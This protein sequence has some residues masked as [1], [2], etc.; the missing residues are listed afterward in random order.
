AHSQLQTYKAEIPSLF[1]FNEILVISDGIEARV[2]SLTANREW[3]LPWRTIE[4]EKA[5][6]NLQ[7]ELETM[8]RGLFDRQRLLLYLR[9]FITFEDDRGKLRKILAGYHQYHAV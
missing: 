5:A 7:P 8:L 6:S 1:D 3:F 9:H 2:G 4:G